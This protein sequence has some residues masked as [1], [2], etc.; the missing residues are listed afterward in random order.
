VH[1]IRP[2]GLRLAEVAGRSGGQRDNIP[3]EGR[4]VNAVW[5]HPTDYRPG[6]ASPIGNGRQTRRTGHP[7]RSLCRDKAGV[8]DKAADCFSRRA[9]RLLWQV[10]YEGAAR[11]HGGVHRRTPKRDSDLN[12]GNNQIRSIQIR[13]A[14]A[15][16]D[17]DPSQGNMYTDPS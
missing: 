1:P 10:V 12:W 8:S 17:R 13:M 2:R 6:L 5:P 7:E 15:R 4:I 16:G 9:Q 14:Q 3:L 11:G